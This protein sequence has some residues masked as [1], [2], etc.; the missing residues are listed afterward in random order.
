ML[1]IEINQ[2]TKKKLMIV[3]IILLVIALILCIAFYIGNSNF[4]S[5]IDRYIL[6][7][8][9]VQNNV[10]SIDISTLENPSIYAY[11]K[12]ITILN[13]NKI[14]AYLSSGKKE[15]EHEILISNAIYASNNR[16][17]VVG[18]KGG[19]NLYCILEQNL[20]WQA[21]VEGEIRKN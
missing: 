3:G 21:E 13:K 4:R 12:Y 7:K 11:D 5:F 9:I 1:K 20:A 8:E 6:R 17:L 16:F 18:E 10:S 19:Q 14:T 15:F 2:I